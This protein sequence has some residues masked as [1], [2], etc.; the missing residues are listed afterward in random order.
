MK[1]KR[2]WILLLLTLSIFGYLYLEARP[3]VLSRPQVDDSVVH[4]EDWLSKYN[5]QRL[6]IKTA[7]S[8]Q[9]QLEKERDGEHN[10]LEN[11]KNRSENNTL[12]SVARLNRSQYLCGSGLFY[13]FWRATEGTGKIE[14]IFYHDVFCHI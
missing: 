4:L 3:G 1:L 6:S 10:A 9:W 13:V 8:T 11:L 2:Y 14:E 7:S 5:Y 12:L